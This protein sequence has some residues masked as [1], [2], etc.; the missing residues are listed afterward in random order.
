MGTA[1]SRAAPPTRDRRSQASTV[2][3]A[4]VLSG[5]ALG[6]ARLLFRISR[7]LQHLARVF[8]RLARDL[9]ATEHSRQFFGTFVHGELGEGGAGGLSVGELGD[10][11]VVMSLA[12]YLRQVGYADR[13][14]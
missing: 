3:P 5:L 1:T 4:G 8:A 11:Q 6:A 10:A 9:E 2:E 13:L 14:A 12:R 7:Q